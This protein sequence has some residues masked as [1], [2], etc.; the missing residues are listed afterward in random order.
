MVGEDFLYVFK[1]R[2]SGRGPDYGRTAN[3]PAPYGLTASGASAYLWT[4]GYA[5][6]AGGTVDGVGHPRW[7]QIVL[8]CPNGVNPA[9]RPDPASG[10]VDEDQAGHE[11]HR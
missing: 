5:P 10:D 1:P 2:P 4:A 6:E 11:L 7:P 8:A 9:T 3:A